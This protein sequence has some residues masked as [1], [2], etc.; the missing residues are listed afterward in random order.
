M[1]HVYPVVDGKP[2]DELNL[3]ILVSPRKRRMILQAWNPYYDG[4]HVIVPYEDREREMP[5]IPFGSRVTRNDMLT[6]VRNYAKYLFSKYYG[7]E[8]P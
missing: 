8:I 3:T 1:F 5:A 7:L 2:L 6:A 4:K